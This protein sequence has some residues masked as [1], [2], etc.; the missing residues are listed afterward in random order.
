MR[1]FAPD[2]TGSGNWARSDAGIAGTR[3]DRLYQTN[4]WSHDRM[5]L[6]FAVARPGTYGVELHLSETWEGA[7]GA[8]KR[9]FDV[10]AEGA[11]VDDDLDIYAH[12]GAN[13][14]LVRRYEV[15]VEDGVLDLDFEG[16][17]QN[18]TIA[19]L[20]IFEVEP[21]ATAGGGRSDSRSV[22]LELVEAVNIG[23]E[24]GYTAANGVVFGADDTGVG[25]SSKRAAPIAGTE[26]D[27]LYHS[28]AWHPKGLDH[29]FDVAD[30]LYLVKLHFAEVWPGAFAEGRRVFDVRAEGSLIDDDLDV[31]R[32]AGG[33]DAALVKGHLVSVDDGALDLELVAGVQNPSLN[34]IELFRLA[35]RPAEV[36]RA[37]NLGSSQTVTAADGTVY[38]ADDTGVGYWHHQPRAVAGTEDDALFASEAWWPAELGYRFAVEDGLYEVELGFAELYDGTKRIGARV[39]DV[40]LEGRLVEVDLDVFAEVGAHAALVRTYRA[41]V[42]DGSLDIDLHGEVENPSVNALKISRVLEDEFALGDPDQRYEVAGLDGGFSLVAADDGF[43]IV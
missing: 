30:G 18:P 43:A 33:R 35:D 40:A 42:D 12:V 38:A 25:R 39:F 4:L 27:A 32:E 6:D 1:A 41:Q 2:T 24:R 10:I 21:H 26:D 23:S 5:S 36:V 37:V 31:F 34:A 17:V 20:R 16:E 22:P 29:R 7:F 13:A 11:V 19:G 9:V 14:A 28:S 3:D 15:E 8:G